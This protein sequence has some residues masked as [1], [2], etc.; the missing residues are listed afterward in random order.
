MIYNKDNETEKRKVKS[1]KIEPSIYDLAI[2]KLKKENKTISCWI[3]N[4]IFDFVSGEGKNNDSGRKK[5]IN[6]KP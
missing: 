6:K 2:S 5:S 3:R 4:Q 1:Y